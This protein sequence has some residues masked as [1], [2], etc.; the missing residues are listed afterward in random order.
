MRQHMNKVC[1]PCEPRGEFSSNAKLSLHLFGAQCMG[2]GRYGA[3]GNSKQTNIGVIPRNTAGRLKIRKIQI[4]CSIQC[5]FFYIRYC[6]IGYMIRFEVLLFDHL[7]IWYQMEL[8]VTINPESIP[9]ILVLKTL[10]TLCN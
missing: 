5:V 4:E 2:E 8:P 10:P 1:G 6:H 9:S 3:W 7:K